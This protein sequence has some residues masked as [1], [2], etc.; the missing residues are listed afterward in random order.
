MMTFKPVALTL[1][2]AISLSTACGAKPPAATTGGTLHDLSVKTID[3]KTKKLSDYKGKVLLIVNT[4]SECGYTRQY[5]G[6]QT[7]YAKMQKSGFEVL[8][9]P[10][11][12]FGQQEPGTD[13]EIKEFCETRYKTTFPLFSKV[14]AKGKDISPIYRFLTMES[15]KQFQ[16]DVSWN[17]TKFLVDKKGHVVGRF[18]SHVSPDASALMSAIEKQVKIQ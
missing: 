14:R 5:A 18:E 11:N 9:F 10:S 2:L 1:I 7:L 16:G 12:D 4:A 15:A 13:S 8:A 3:G 6:L 17:F